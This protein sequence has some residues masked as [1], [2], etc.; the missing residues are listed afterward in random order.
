MWPIVSFLILPDA[1][2]SAL[3]DALQ[4]R[5]EATQKGLL[6]HLYQAFLFL[7]Y[8]KIYQIKLRLK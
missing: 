1:T 6:P 8:K 2:T 4:C 5:K 7:S 3:F